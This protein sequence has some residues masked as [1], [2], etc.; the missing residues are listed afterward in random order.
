M[1]KMLKLI[2]HGIACEIEWSYFEKALRWAVV[3]NAWW[4]SF[5]I[6]ELLPKNKSNFHPGS[7]LLASDVKFTEESIAFWIRSPKVEK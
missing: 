1:S 3:L 7:T 5:R 2:G 6:G 4:G